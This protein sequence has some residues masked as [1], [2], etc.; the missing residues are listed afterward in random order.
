MSS[1]VGVYGKCATAASKR[2]VIG[3]TKSRL[4]SLRRNI[5]AN[6]VAPGFIA[7]DMTGCVSDAQREAIVS[8]IGSGRLAS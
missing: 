2:G 5:T 7:T 3:L 1:V 8:R 6:A 4:G